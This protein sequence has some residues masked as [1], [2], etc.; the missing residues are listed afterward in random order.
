MAK[1]KAK[2][3]KG[4][5]MMTVY[6]DFSADFEIDGDDS[7]LAAGFAGGLEDDRLS[8]IMVTAAEAL[9]HSRREKQTEEELFVEKAAKTAKPVK[10]AA[11][12]KKAVKK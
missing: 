6:D 3:E 5:I 4:H 9:L 2:K 11:S 1:T 12:K 10:K 7:W 8:T